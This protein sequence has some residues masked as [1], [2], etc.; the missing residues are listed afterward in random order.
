MPP[1][2]TARVMAALPSDDRAA[3]P[4]RLRHRWQLPFEP[5][6]H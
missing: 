2:V 3:Q 6:S 4:A 1:H 5:L